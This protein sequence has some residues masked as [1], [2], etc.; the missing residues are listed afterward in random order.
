MNP[1]FPIDGEVVDT[2][3]AWHVRSYNQYYHNTL[4][5]YE[6]CLYQDRVPSIKC[7]NGATSIFILILKA[8]CNVIS[9]YI[10]LIINV[11][12]TLLGSIFVNFKVLL[13][14]SDILIFI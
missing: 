6:Y 9:M 8:H 14:I 13:L 5:W 10:Y 4:F 12:F 11:I 7:C 3:Q 2:S 1:E